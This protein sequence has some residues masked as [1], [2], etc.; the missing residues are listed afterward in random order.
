MD[1]QLS[2]VQDCIVYH[3]SQVK[4]L[5]TALIHSSYAN[6]REDAS[7][8]NERLE[9]LGDAVLELCVSEEAFRRY[10]EAT[11]GQMTRI[12]SGLVKERSL[13]AAARSLGLDQYLLL[14][15][16]EEAQGGRQRDALL[17]DAL[18][19][20]FGAVFLDGGFQAAKTLILRLFEDNWPESPDM[21]PA[22]DHKSRLQEITQQRFRSLPVYRLES[23]DGPEHAKVF[24]VEVALSDG[25]LFYGQGGSVKRAEQVAASTAIKMLETE[26]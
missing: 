4:L 9:F 24:R 7:E 18:E 21:R 25:R 26:E 13:A 19:A 12:R 22:K 20:V 8:D 15:K 10:P 2:N 6:E 1:E 3:F 17:A 16:G 11:E 23:T 5:R 14:G